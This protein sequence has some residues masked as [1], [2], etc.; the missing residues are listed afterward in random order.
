VPNLEPRLQLSP[1]IALAAASVIL[2]FAALPAAADNL[3][4]F[5]GQGEATNWKTSPKANS[6]SQIEYRDY[7]LS[8]D[9]VK[10]LEGEEKA[11]EDQ[12]QQQVAGKSQ[13]VARN[14][15]KTEEKPQ[16]S[17]SSQPLSREQIIA[18]YGAPDEERPIQAQK[19]APPEMKGLIAA[20]NSGDKELA[21][22]YA[23]AL[24]RRDTETQKV[25]SKV[26]DYRLLAAEAL[27]IRQ[28]QEVDANKE[29]DPTRLEV[30]E[31]MEKVRREELQKKM[32]LEKA[33]KGAEQTGAEDS[34][35]V[36]PGSTGQGIEEGEIPVDPAGKVR[37]LVFFDENDPKIKDLTTPLRQILAKF[38]DDRDTSL[39]GL[40]RRSYANPGLKKVAAATSFPFPIL[41]GEALALD[42]RIHRYP[43]FVFV[44]PTTKERYRL[45]GLRTPEEI[46]KVIRLMKG[47]R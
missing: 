16:N 1:L 22:K 8:I 46:E 3:K 24:A 44:A 10:Q 5:W 43:T 15:E 30:R 14:I 20:M 4:G 36:K 42:L 18:Q 26:T 27:G 41:N 31:Y 33:L 11:I 6:S 9:Q 28:S 35:Q 21:F 39:L 45:D 7:P 2:A 25:V 38:K 17:D 29:I 19:D 23:V 37:L 13:D 32:D 40:T 34:W 12:I 47:G